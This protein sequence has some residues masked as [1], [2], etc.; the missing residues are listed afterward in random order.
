[1]QPDTRRT[2]APPRSGGRRGRRSCKT[3]SA[4]PPSPLSERSILEPASCMPAVQLAVLLLRRPTGRPWR[5]T[6]W[7]TSTRCRARGESSEMPR[8]RSCSSVARSPIGGM[9]S[10]SSNRRGRCLRAGRRLCCRQVRGSR[11]AAHPYRPCRGC[12]PR[13]VAGGGDPRSPD[14]G[15]QPRRCLPAAACTCRRSVVEQGLIDGAVLRSAHLKQCRQKG[16]ELFR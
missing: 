8:A 9:P 13:H 6:S 11:E 5:E 16:L 12:C 2:D 4:G 15:R 14:E 7:R 1:M 3:R 10:P